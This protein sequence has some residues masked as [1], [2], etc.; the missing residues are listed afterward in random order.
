VRPLVSPDGKLIAIRYMN[1]P[2]SRK[3]GMALIPFEGG[4]PV[5]L[6]D[7]SAFFVRW[8]HDGHALQYVNNR[9]G[10][11]NIWSQ[12]I[13]GG[14]PR[15]LTDFKS[16][17]LFAFAWSTDGKQLAVSRG[18]AAEDVVLINNFR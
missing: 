3:F 4:E 14:P 6:F 12:P 1:D 8:S 13:D 16:D 11:S 10:S 9:G 5:K 2:A 7:I 15:Q 17:K 18:V